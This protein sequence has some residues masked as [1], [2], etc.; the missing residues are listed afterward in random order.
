MSEGITQFK[1]VHVIH[2]PQSYGLVVQHKS[3]IK[4]SYSGDTIPC[5]AFIR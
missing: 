4:V 3:G 5:P 2:C 1:P